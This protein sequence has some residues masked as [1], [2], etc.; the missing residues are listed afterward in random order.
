MAEKK[1]DEKTILSKGLS[2][3][4]LSKSAKISQAQQYTLFAVLGAGLF[5]GFGLAA[6]MHFVDQISFNAEVISKQD[7]SIVSFSNAIKG[8]GIC[9]K[10]KGSTYTDEEL[11]KCNPNNIDVISIPN[12]LR[13][14]ILLKLAADDALNS[15]PKE[16]DSSCINPDTNK[17]F[18]YQ[19]LNDIYDKA[20]NVEE[21]TSATKLIQ[22]CSALRVIPDA[23]PSSRN[24]EALLSSLNKLFD[25]SGWEPE[26]ISP[27]GE[28][29]VASFDSN[30][31]TISVRLAAETNFSTMMSILRN[32]ESSI[33]EFDI[34]RA[35]IEWSGENSIT[36]QARANA[37]YVDIAKLEPTI[38]KI[39]GKGDN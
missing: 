16:D 11:K 35:T 7:E 14:N 30:L 3:I 22:N 8:I 6:I 19:E 28:Y 4:A 29:D 38:I 33:R 5:L 20:S 15:V 2:K 27:M 32:I 17:N 12:T 34:K 24:E 31:N 37:F 36:L 18:T 10:P 23:L 39:Q 1:V 9:T 21:L 26:R 13:S 25:L